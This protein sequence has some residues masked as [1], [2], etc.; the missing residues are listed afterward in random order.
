MGAK[1]LLFFLRRVR[2]RDNFATPAGLIGTRL[3]DPAPGGGQI[4]T[5]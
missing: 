2:S 1:S 5:P 4:A 3:A